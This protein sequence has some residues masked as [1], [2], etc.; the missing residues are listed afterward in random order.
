MGHGLL[1]ATSKKMHVL[2]LPFL[3]FFLLAAPIICSCSTLADQNDPHLTQTDHPSHHQEEPDETGNHPHQDHQAC[4]CSHV[5]TSGIL[6]EK[7]SLNHSQHSF[8]T[9]L[10]PVFHHHYLSALRT[11]FYSSY[12]PPPLS[13]VLYL[14]KSSFLI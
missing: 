5:P 3:A 1:Q 7:V 12:H 11:K 14:T 8:L 2:L 6:N 4:L 10:Q 13:T 9:V